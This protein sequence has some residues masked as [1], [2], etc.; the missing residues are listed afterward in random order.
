M[1]APFSVQL[2][3]DQPAN[4]GVLLDALCGQYHLLVS[5]SAESFLEQL[6]HAQ[7]D[8]ILLD[9]CMPGMDGF[10]LCA[11]LKCSPEWR[12][13]PIIFMTALDRPDEIVRALDLGAVD[14]ITKPFHA[15][16][17]VAR[18]RTHLRLLALARELEAQREALQ[19]EVDMRRETETHLQHSLDQAILAVDPNGRIVFQTRHAASLLYRYCAHAPNQGL[20]AAFQAAWEAGCRG[21]MSRWGLPHPDGTG[22]LAVCL[23]SNPEESSLTLFRMEEEG[24]ASAAALRSLGLSPRESEVLFWIAEGK[25]YPEIGL[26]IETSVRTVEKHAE[27]LIRKLEVESKAGAMRIALETLRSPSAT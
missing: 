6:P 26:I 18:V 1:A 7:P 8:L 5:E 16:E 12:D 11:Q 13:I 19:T 22:R 10:D 2:I 15:Q 21:G 3:D 27:N 17:V 14:Y 23:F 4:I 9:V 24:M 20:P 25:T